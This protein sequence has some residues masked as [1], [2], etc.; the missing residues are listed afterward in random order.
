VLPHPAHVIMQLERRHEEVLAEV[1]RERRARLAEQRGDWPSRQQVLELLAALVF[2]AAL[3]LVVAAEATAAPA[4]A[5]AAPIAAAV[6][7]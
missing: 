1:A 4:S 5:A 6:L 2:L 3:A 7:P